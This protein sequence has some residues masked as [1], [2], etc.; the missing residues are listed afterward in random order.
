[1]K[2]EIMIW[3]R[4]HLL[5]VVLPGL[6]FVLGLGIGLGSGQVLKKQD[7]TPAPLLSSL[8]E[9]NL[10]PIVLDISKSDGDLSD[11]EVHAILAPYK[12]EGG[13]AAQQEA[14][15]QYLLRLADSGA[16][17]DQICRELRER[18]SPL[19]RMNIFKLAYAAAMADGQLV[20]PE[21][22]RLLR[23]LT[24]LD[25]PLPGNS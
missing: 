6:V 21:R 8:P 7:T 15:K 4:E 12:R 9:I 18:A 17:V 11:Q 19:E 13:S 24:K 22:E 2:N 14:S 20:P 25:L 1:M 23:L 10:L 3:S 16:N 5:S